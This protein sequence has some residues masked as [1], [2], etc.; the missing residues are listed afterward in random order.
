MSKRGIGKLPVYK[1]YVSE[2]AADVD[3]LQRFLLYS[4]P[5]RRVSEICRMGAC[6]A[7]EPA[8]F[9]VYTGAQS[10]LS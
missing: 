2:I 8:V 10:V 1:K 4:R 7:L 3:D 9:G 6:G 5:C